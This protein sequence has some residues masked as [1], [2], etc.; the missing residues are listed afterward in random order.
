MSTHLTIDPATLAEWLSDG[1]EIAL[2]DLREK[3]LYGEGH[4][5]F[6]SNVPYSQLEL[7]IERLVPRRGVRIVLAGEEASDLAGARRLADLGYRAVYRLEGGVRAWFEAGHAAFASVHAPS[8]AFAEVVERR[9]GTPEITATE[10]KRLLDGEADV[11]VLDSRTAEE[12]ARRH[13]PGA[14][15]CPGAELVYRFADLAPSPETYVVVSCAG[16][17]RGLIGAQALIDAGVPNRVAALS[18]GTQGWRL[19][20]Y[21]LAS[22]PASGSG[23]ASEE[24]RQIALAR[25]EALARRH[26][27]R[28]ISGQELD[29]WRAEA[30]RTLYLFDVRAPAEYEAGHL[31][32]SWSVPGGQLIQGLDAWAATRGARIVLFDERSVRAIMTAHWLQQMGWEVAVLSEPPLDAVLETGRT[33]ISKPAPAVAPVVSAAEA[34][35]L[36]S[37]GAAALSTDASADYRQAHPSAALW[38]NRSRLAAIDDVIR[39]AKSLVLFGED[40][41]RSQLVARDIAEA[42]P[43][44]VISVVAGGPEEWRAAG[45]PIVSSADS[46]PDSDRVDF[47]FW[48]HD[49][50]AGNAESSQ[51]YLAWEL[52]LPRQIGSPEAAG[53]RIFSGDPPREPHRSA[54]ESA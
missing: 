5:F 1:E 7:L 18:G 23:E 34:A 43:E 49:R 15:S 14:R 24:A 48:L 37:E 11:V 40:V 25:A 8:K 39:T 32:G 9:S 50:H 10:L 28:R 33:P 45:L 31:P 17:T 36:L 53:F 30:D 22:G 26:R 38:V 54:E 27:I 19:A 29:V 46:P 51:A 52:D 6:A 44:T 13:V 20:G 12:F 41:D 3:G 4:A 2:L 16:R 47:L 35:R 42:F 21:Q